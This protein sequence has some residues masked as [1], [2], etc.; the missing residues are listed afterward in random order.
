MALQPFFH[1]HQRPLQGL[2]L[3]PP[4]YRSQLGLVYIC[5]IWGS[6]RGVRRDACV[7]RVWLMR[8][9]LIFDA[10]MARMRQ[11]YKMNRWLRCMSRMHICAVDATHICMSHRFQV[12]QS[13]MMHTRLIRVSNTS[14]RHTYNICHM[15]TDV[16]M[17]YMS[18]F[19]HMLVRMSHVR[20]L[21]LMYERHTRLIHVSSRRRS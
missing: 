19:I 20:H 8:I 5:G 13:H 10:Y 18:Y 17:S 3:S 21:R 11:S 15:R 4:A 6:Y 2:P 9:W 14:I 7:K 1:L 12:H 16:H